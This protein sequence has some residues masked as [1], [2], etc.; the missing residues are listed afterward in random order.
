MTAQ[1]GDAAVADQLQKL[2]MIDSAGP[3]GG[4]TSDS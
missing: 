1:G 2:R 4:I 3:L